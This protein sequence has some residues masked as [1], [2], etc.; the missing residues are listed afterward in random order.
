MFDYIVYIYVLC[1]NV[2][3]SIGKFL[4]PHTETIKILYSVIL[5]AVILGDITTTTKNERE[6]YPSDV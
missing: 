6:K 4:C 1:C 5:M 3:Q 2:I